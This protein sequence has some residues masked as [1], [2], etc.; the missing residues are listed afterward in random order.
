MDLMLH[1]KT[2]LVTGGSEGIG[3]GIAI[4]LAKEINLDTSDNAVIASTGV[5]STMIKL[6]A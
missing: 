6:V 4:A 1:G 5:P 2:A 3:K